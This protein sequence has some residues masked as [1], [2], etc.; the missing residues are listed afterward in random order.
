MLNLARDTKV[1]PKIS[2]TVRH[3]K[4]EHNAL[5]R[6]V[7]G[8]EPNIC[9]WQNLLVWTC[10]HVHVCMLPVTGDWWWTWMPYWC[11][12][13]AGLVLAV[14]PSKGLGTTTL[15]TASPLIIWFG[16]PRHPWSQHQRSWTW[17]GKCPGA[18]TLIF[19]CNMYP[20]ATT[21]AVSRVSLCSS[22]SYC[23]CFKELGRV[24]NL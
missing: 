13:A 23:Q 8:N 5:L 16:H 7:F 18:S 2:S 12:L 1:K 22:A 9:W 20:T 19:Y 14:I 15:N 21:V 11:A 6:L 4:L 3:T 24:S 17:H 10:Q